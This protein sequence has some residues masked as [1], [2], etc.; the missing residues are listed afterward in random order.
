MFTFYGEAT[1]EAPAQKVYEA[2][3]DFESYSKWNKYTPTIK[4]PNGSKA[5][6]VDDMITLAYRPEPHGNTM[7]VP[8]RIISISDEERSICWRGCVKSIPTSALLPEKVQTV[9]PQGENRCLYRI[10]ETQAGPLAYAVKWTL[11]KKLSVRFRWYN[12]YESSH[13]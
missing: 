4:T 13:R 12:V 11:G 1:I 2:L 5:L 6:A 9:T 7:D 10:Y 8:C 3:R